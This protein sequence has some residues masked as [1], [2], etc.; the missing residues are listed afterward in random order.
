[1]INLLRGM[2]SRTALWLQRGWPFILS[3]FIVIQ[4]VLAM[5]W[6]V[7]AV[8]TGIIAL[9]TVM[10]FIRDV[11]IAAAESG[12]KKVEWI[13]AELAQVDV[14]GVQHGQLLTVSNQHYWWSPGVDE[15]LW[16]EELGVEFSRT[17]HRLPG[18]LQHL[19]P[20]IVA[21]RRDGGALLFNGKVLRLDSDLMPVGP[22]IA[23]L[24]PARYF[25][26]LASNYMC[27]FAITDRSYPQS[28][29]VGRDFLV[30]RNNRMRFLGQSWSV[31]P[32]GV[33]TLAFTSDDQL[34]LVHQSQRNVSEQDRLAPS[35]SG[36]AEPK[37]VT[38]SSDTLQD[39]LIRGMEREFQQ[40]CNV[41]SARCSTKVIGYS[42]WLDKGGKPE[43]YGVTRV[44]ISESELKDVRIG[45]EEKR[46]VTRVV[47]QSLDWERLI[48]AAR[49]ED[50]GGIEALVRGSASSP[51]IMALM[52]LG[53]RLHATPTL[54]SDLGKLN[55]CNELRST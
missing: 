46:L 15:V 13:G 2:T 3:A 45:S 24:R 51:L 40:E 38:G 21:H 36:S 26:A 30:D 32:I 4:T 48:N 17:P 54:L 1:M 11:F 9:L 25:D 7:G 28:V 42:R 52:L 18:W 44:D 16:D 41:R 6:P 34:I 20:V 10:V 27:G 29:A 55:E 33:S 22:Q 12:S 49:S 8:V 39:V 14:S 50:L 31:N 37:D 5:L 43:F 53:R 23:Y 19:V 35:G 47:T